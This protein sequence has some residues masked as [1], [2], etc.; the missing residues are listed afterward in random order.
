[1]RNKIPI[2]LVAAL[3][4]FL[5][6]SEAHAQRRMEKLDRGVVAV[7]EGGGKVFV[8]WRL[9]GNDPEGI[10]FNLYRKTGDGEAVRL[11]K[12]PLTG[13]TCFLDENTPTSQTLSWFV[14][15]VLDKK[16]REASRPWTLKPDARPYLEIPLRTPQ[17]YQPNDASVGDLDGDGAYEIVLHQVGRGID[18]AGQ[19][20]CSNPIFQ[21]YKLDGTFL[22]EINLGQNIREGAHYNQFIVLDLDGDGKAEFCCKTAD[23]ARD[24]QGKVVGDPGKD[25]RDPNGRIIEGPEF[26]TV[27]NGATGA[28]LATADYIPPRGNLGGWGGVGGNGGNDRIGNRADRFLACA[29]WLDG[30]LPSVVMCRGIYGRSVLAAWDWRGGQLTSRWVFDTDKGYPELAGMGNHN[31][32]VADV[33]GDGKDEIVYGAMAVD[34][35]GKGLYTTRLRHGDALHVGDLDPSRSG[36]EVW[37]IHENEA[38][39]RGYENGFGAAL[40]DARTGEILFGIGPGRDVGR[41]VAADID[42][43][44]SGAEMWGGSRELLDVHGKA[45]GPAPRT[46]NFIIY[47][48]DDPLSELLNGNTITKWD[49]QG[50]KETPLFTAEGCQSNNGSKS[51]PCLSADILGDWREE[52]IERTRDNTAL[53]IFT[54]M[55]PTRHRMYTLMHDPVYRNAIAWQNA[56]Y[57]QPPHLGFFMDAEMKNIPRPD[58]VTDVE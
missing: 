14:K 11:N 21:A 33:D 52:L 15:P 58:I 25:W 8:S 46:T 7:N 23:G 32:S 36:L 56:G 6:A 54:T 10:A 29:A 37:G 17:G 51:T 5:M 2:L 30:K 4:G 16:E 45:I 27:F 20:F 53:R 55:I 50:G 13:A 43:R 12:E 1:M 26:F 9:F 48:D 19:G 34:H 24:G 41:G 28:A 22:W 35:D 47:W 44:Y 40:F 18:G 57:N 42:P 31:L 3:M 49:W 39:V 38:P